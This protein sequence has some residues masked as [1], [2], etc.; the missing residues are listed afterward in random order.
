M[1]KSQ[2]R[3][4]PVE[5]ATYTAYRQALEDFRL[6]SSARYDRVL[7]ML[8]GGALA[9]SL[10]I[11]PDLVEACHQEIVGKWVLV[12]AWIAL[13]VTILCVGLSFFVAAESASTDIEKLDKKEMENSLMGRDKDA[14]WSQPT[15]GRRI[16]PWLNA[17]GGILFTIGLAL[18]V[19]FA[20]RN[21]G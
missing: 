20:S 11:A 7:L 6:L 19:I 3:P 8:S 9:A 15:S 21:F 16:I 5:G 12:G 14:E 2:Q 1:R 10:S 17:I 4:A 18:M 13:G